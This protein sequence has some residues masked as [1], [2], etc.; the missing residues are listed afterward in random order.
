MI[1]GALDCKQLGVCRRI[2]RSGYEHTF[3][4]TIADFVAAVAS[5]KKVRPPLKSRSAI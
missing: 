1:T 4:H 5:R 3:T 2:G